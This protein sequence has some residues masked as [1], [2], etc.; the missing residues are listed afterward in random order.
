MNARTCHLHKEVALAVAYNDFE[1]TE[2]LEM[3][4]IEEVRFEFFDEV[5]EQVA[6]EL[7]K[8]DHERAVQ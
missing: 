3:G 8:Q 1:K 5:L 2:D 7:G 6:Q 4:A